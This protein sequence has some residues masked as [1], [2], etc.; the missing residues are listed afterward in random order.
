MVEATAA[1]P[2]DNM[3]R[4]EIKNHLLALAER[5]VEARSTYRSLRVDASK[6]LNVWQS[7]EEGVVLTVCTMKAEGITMDDIRTFHNPDQF[8]ANM[9]ILDPIITCRRLE[10]DLGAEGCYAIYQH[11]KTPMIVSN[12]C[13]FMAVYNI[14]TPNGGF[15]ALSTSKGMKP[16]EQANVALQAKDVLSHTV[17]TYNKFEACEDGSGVRVTAVLCV[18]PAGSLPD[19]IKTKIATQNSNTADNMVKHLRKQKGLR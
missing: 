6:E 10:D 16:I 12:R 5:H 1:D 2:C 3:S 11:I 9:H 4:E 8:P 15:I 14:D 19:F 7:T 13:C 18:D 17:V